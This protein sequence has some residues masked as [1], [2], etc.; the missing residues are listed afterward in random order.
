MG[1]P[2]MVAGTGRLCTDLMT[3]WPG[4]V[5]SKIGA[6][7]VYGAAIPELEL[8]VALK[9][10]D[11]DMPSSGRALLEVLRQLLSRMAPDHTGVL[12]AAALV[13]HGS[14]PIRNTRDV[15]TGELRTAGELR[16]FDG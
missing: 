6:E 7:G 11:G 12:G 13:R 4:G 10:E 1:H 9:V 8:G 3:A 16:F 2:L 14:Q 15:I 5:V